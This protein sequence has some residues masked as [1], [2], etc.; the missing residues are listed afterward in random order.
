MDEKLAAM[1]QKAAAQAD[2]RLDRETFIDR[3]KR[4]IDAVRQSVPESAKASADEVA[5]VGAMTLLGPPTHTAGPPPAPQRQ[6]LLEL[7]DKYGMDR[8]DEIAT[9]YGCGFGRTCSTGPG[10]DWQHRWDNAV[11]ELT[12]R[13]VRPAV[14]NVH[15][16]LTG[17]RLPG[18]PENRPY[19]DLENDACRLATMFVE[20]V[21]TIQCK[22]AEVGRIHAAP[23]GG[24]EVKLSA[25]GIDIALVPPGSRYVFAPTQ[26][27][28]MRLGEQWKDEAAAGARVRVLAR[29]IDAHISP[30]ERGHRTVPPGSTVI[31]S[32]SAKVQVW[33]CTCGWKKCE[34][35][36]RLASW[37]PARHCL[38]NFTTN[39]VCGPNRKHS[40]KSLING[41]YV[42]LL[43]HE[44]FSSCHDYAR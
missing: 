39:A 43:I 12:R 10:R 17:R 3:V 35:Q 5:V 15:D 40:F 36:H 28:R 6:E 11:N 37:E 1:V 4:A 16:W 25:S 41:M 34:E 8:L 42:P 23:Q 20:P 24:V 13:A 33:E 22:K 19:G 38:W 44:G 32:D 18:Y 2:G 31:L 21:K 27:L 7:L 29:D 26:E 9:A 30:R 14:N